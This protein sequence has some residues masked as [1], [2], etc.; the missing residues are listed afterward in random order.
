M[1]DAARWGENCIFSDPFYSHPNGYK[2]RLRL[3]PNGSN[4]GHN[5]H[6]SL[7]LTL[8]HGPND[9][10]LEWPYK[11]RTRVSIINPGNGEDITRIVDPTKG[12]SEEAW[13]RPTQSSNTDCG[14]ETMLPHSQLLTYLKQ[15]KLLIT[16]NILDT[17]K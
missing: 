8:L 15:D 1:R 5:S 2:M 17:G 14:W 13:R 6:V 12:G 10:H 7:Y 16:V 3:L 9:A 4:N 11:K